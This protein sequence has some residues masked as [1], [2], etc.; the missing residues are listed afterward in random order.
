MIAALYVE[1]GGCYYGLPDVDP[2]DEERDAR[3]YAGPWPVVAHPP[4]GQWGNF[5]RSGMTL[6]PLGD[7]DGCFAAALAAVRKW[8]GVLEHPA[9]SSAWAAHSILEPLR[10]GWYNADSIGGWTC[11]VDQAHYGHPCRKST[12]LYAVAPT[13]SLRWRRAPAEPGA[14]DQLGHRER[15]ATPVAFR[16]VLLAIA[17]S[18]RPVVSR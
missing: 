10:G 8:G 4:C 1:K 12:W 15:A 17:R 11:E 5:A 6:R 3:L 16:D 2:W 14:F 7:D 9:H 18:V 13:P